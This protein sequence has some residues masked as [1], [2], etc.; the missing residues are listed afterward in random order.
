M[1]LLLRPR[2]CCSESFVAVACVPATHTHAGATLSNQ[3][4]KTDCST[5]H[6]AVKHVHNC[7]Q[8]NCSQ[9]ICQSH[10]SPI[11]DVNPVQCHIVELCCGADVLFPVICIEVQV[12][13]IGDKQIAHALR[14]RE[15]C[16]RATSSASG[17]L[18]ACVPVGRGATKQCA[19][20]YIL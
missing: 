17:A 11:E 18:G 16:Q 10:S 8:A 20:L 15:A 2:G 3:L 12:F 9:Y 19:W 7:M 1:S 5:P 4:H 6:L 14:S 13:A